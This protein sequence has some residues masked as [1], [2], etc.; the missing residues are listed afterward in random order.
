MTGLRGDTAGV[1]SHGCRDVSTLQYE[2]WYRM[3]LKN[4]HAS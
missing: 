4:Y 3:D 2:E 1:R